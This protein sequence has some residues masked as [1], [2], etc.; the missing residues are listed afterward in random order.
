MLDLL[1]N[2]SVEEI[3]IFIVLLALAVKEVINFFDWASGRLRSKFTKDNAD[4]QIITELKVQIEGLSNQL[5]DYVNG[6]ASYIEEDSRKQQELRDS[7]TLLMESDKDDIKSWIT[8]KHHYFCY[9][10]GYIDDYSLDCIEKRF[11]HYR[12]E[13]GNSFVEDLMNDLRHLPKVIQQKEK[14]K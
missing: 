13:G 11:K 7:I 12:D 1:K 10:K 6:F 8:E 2:Y 5:K 9:E 14:N 3:I 4:E